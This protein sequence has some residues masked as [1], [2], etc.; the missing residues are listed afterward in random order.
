MRGHIRK[1]GKGSSWEVKIDLPTTTSER[2]KT[3]YC[4]VRG[5]RKDAERELAR[6][7][8]AAHDGTLPEPNRITVA[9]YLTN[10]LDGAHGLAAKTKERYLALTQQQIIPHLGNIALQK[11]R[12]A[13]IA[14]WHSKLLREGGKDGRPLSGRTTG[15]AHRVLHTA[16]ARAVKS[17][18][19]PRN[20]ASVIKPPKVEEQEVDSLK[21]DEISTV[22]KA[23]DGHPLHAVAITALATGARRGELLALTWGNIDLDKA[24]M[25]I[26]RSLEQTKAGLKFKQPKT[27]TSRR[28]ISLPPMTV[29]ALRTHRRQQLEVRVALG[30]GRPDSNTLVFSD[31]EGNPIPPNNLSRDWRRFVKARKLPSVSFHGLRH[32]HV[33]ALIARSIDVLTVSRRIGHASPVVTL[34]VYAHMFQQTDTVAASAIEAALKGER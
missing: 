32:S 18:L 25:K 31:V 8:S 34:R 21:A 3:H 14:D 17:E 16:L 24:T 28:T 30:Q 26:E 27:K 13:H 7:I 12:P 15:H 23:L 29:D 6:L 22:L 1:R 20:V 10:W 9:D 11:L 4:T 5:S 2:R 33:S 19:V